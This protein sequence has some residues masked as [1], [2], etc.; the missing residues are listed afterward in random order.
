MIKLKNKFL[1]FLHAQK[2]S[3]Q[4]TVIAYLIISLILLEQMDIIHRKMLQVRY[5]GWRAGDINLEKK[6]V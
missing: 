4:D 1:L 3:V 6:I 5:G 2:A